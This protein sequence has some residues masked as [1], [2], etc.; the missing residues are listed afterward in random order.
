MRDAPV[1]VI[2][3]SSSIV[4]CW[5]RRELFREYGRCGPGV[6]GFCM[7]EVRGGA[8]LANLGGAPIALLEKPD[9][10]SPP[11]RAGVAVRFGLRR[12]DSGRGREGRPFGLNCGLG[13]RAPGPTD[14]ENL[15]SDG[16]SGLK[17]GFVVVDRLKLLYDGVVGVGGKSSDVAEERFCAR[18]TGR[19]MPDPETEVLKYFLLL[20]CQYARQL[21]AAA[22]THPS[23]SPLFFPR[24]AYSLLSSTPAK[25]PFLLDTAPIN[26]TTPCMPPGT[27][28]TSPT[29]MSR[30]SAPILLAGGEAPPTRAFREAFR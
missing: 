20:C 22:A 29:P 24:D 30:P 16:V 6:R 1:G 14:C 18:C 8:G 28:T 10:V 26:L 7:P 2:S 3:V 9:G 27:S 4:S 21:L 12:G 25:T 17:W 5:P 13:A 11:F 23:T 19:N 15:G